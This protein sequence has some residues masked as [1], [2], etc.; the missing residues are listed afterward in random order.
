MQALPGLVL[1]SSL[2][3]ARPRKKAA[4]CSLR[5]STNAGPVNSPP[6]G[7]SQVPLWWDWLV[8]V[9]GS[10]GDSLHLL[11]RLYN[12]PCR[13]FLMFKISPIFLLCSCIFNL[14][15]ACDWTHV[16]TPP[17]PHLPTWKEDSVWV[18][19]CSFLDTYEEFIRRSLTL[20]KLN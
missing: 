8:A 16:P 9:K 14:W 18:W 1:K 2:W 15:N 3:N 10:R 11:Q 4:S 6:L 7:C 19:V 20:A 17:H 5:L 12:S 13:H